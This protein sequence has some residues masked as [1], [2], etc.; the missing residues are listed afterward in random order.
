LW[1]KGAAI[2]AAWRT[3]GRLNQWHES[4][5]QATNE[6]ADRKSCPKFKAEQSRSALNLI[7]ELMFSD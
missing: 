7:V 2:L 3:S 4:A 5:A 1:A 6:Q